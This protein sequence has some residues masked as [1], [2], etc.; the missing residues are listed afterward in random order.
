MQTLPLR[1]EKL[2]NRVTGVN[3]VHSTFIIFYFIDDF[4]YSGQIKFY[5]NRL[6]GG[7]ASS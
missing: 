4:N 1:N 5:E 3:S 6:P 7:K 2:G